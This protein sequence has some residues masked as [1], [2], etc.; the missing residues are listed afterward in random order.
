MVSLYFHIPF[1]TRKCPYCHFFVV[2]NKKDHREDFLEALLIECRRILPKIKDHLVTSIYFGGGTPTLLGAT[3]IHILLESIPFAPDCEITI[4]ANPEDVTEELMANFKQAGIN[5]VSLGVQ[6]LEDSSLQVLERTHNATKAIEAIM[7]TKNA[8]ISN[9]SIDLMYELPDQTLKDFEKTLRKLE[10]LP[11]THL[12]LYNLT[13]E[14]NTA[15]FK[16]TLNLPSPE[17]NLKLL[18]SATDHLEEMGLKRYEISAFAREGF[19]SHHNTGYWIG[20]PFFGLGPSAFSYY[21]GKRF[22]NIPHLHRYMRALK[23]NRSAVDFVEKLPYPQN[24]HELLAINLRL[25]EGVDLNTFD[26]PEATHALLDK[27]H[28][29]NYLKRDGSHCK[30][31]PKGI[32]FYDTVASEII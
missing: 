32:L 12:S 29:E 7:H 3:A 24:V 20:R 31:T 8:G 15:F 5:R 28:A 23:E 18:Q 25:L 22:R 9:I 10:T 14:P 19:A 6:S 27:L 11:I 17:E 30:L 26:L 4:E 13:I 21:E 1:C 2:P 16:R